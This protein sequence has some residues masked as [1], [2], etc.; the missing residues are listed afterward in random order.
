MPRV[1]SPSRTTWRACRVVVIALLTCALAA[2][3]ALGQTGMEA[4]KKQATKP[5]TKIA[6]GVVFVGMFDSPSDVGDARTG[7]QKVRDFFK[8]RNDD[9]HGERP[10]VCDKVLDILVGDRGTPMPVGGTTVRPTAITTDTHGRV[11]VLEPTTRTV[12][13]FDFAEHKYVRFLVSSEN[14]QVT[15]EAIAVDADDNIYVTDTQRRMIAVFEP[16]GKFKEFL[17]HIGGESL[18]E[19]PTALAI[20]RGTGRI[21]VSDTN[22][23]YIVVLDHTG[24]IVAEIGRRGGGSGPGQFHFPTQL[25]IDVDELFV[26]DKFNKRIQVLDLQGRFRREI[27]MERLGLDA[28]KG[29]AV[30]SKRQIYLALDAGF[31]AVV[32]AKGD[33]VLEFG[34]YGGEFGEFRGPRGIYIDSEDRL[35]V[36]DTGNRRVQMFRVNN[37]TQQAGK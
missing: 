6:E 19:R 11:L 33:R 36:S 20:D 2:S 5:G 10:A 22:R 23:H 26:Y 16:D 31:I 13:I 32:N 8:G 17:G 37:Q 27:S 7:C 12:H 18:F 21:Y 25:A 3:A 34:R 30:D 14:R 4:G 15:P 35:Y 1:T 29:I 28:P 9:I 24:K